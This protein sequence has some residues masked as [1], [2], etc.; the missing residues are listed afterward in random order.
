MEVKTFGSGTRE[1][2]RERI[3]NP[4]DILGYAVGWETWDKVTQGL[5]KN[6][7]TVICGESKTGKSTLLINFSKIL[8]FDM[9]IPGLYIDTEMDTDEQEDRLIAII[10]KVPFEE[11]RNGMYVRDT[12]YG[13]AV[14]KIPAVDRAVEML[15]TSKLK[16][17][18]MPSFTID[19][20]AALVRKYKIQDNIG[21][22]VFDYIKMPDSEVKNLQNAQEWQRLGYFTSCLK[23]LCGMCKIP[24]LTAAQANRTSIGNTN[25]DANSLGG[26]YRILQ[27]ATRL[28]F[29]RNKLDTELI[30]ENNSRGNQVLKIAY[31]R[32]GSSTGAE[33]DIQFNRPILEMVEVGRR[34]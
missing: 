26:S 4:S 15:E 9:N 8:S 13:N 27:I 7:L 14:D 5:Q 23:N 1:R 12:A 21:Y 33:I 17:A 34:S 19:K 29:I 28:C 24:C 16:H 11:I 2:L 22:F 6:D 25:Q 3:E 18:Y 32:H 30:M 31:Q 10:S 20:V